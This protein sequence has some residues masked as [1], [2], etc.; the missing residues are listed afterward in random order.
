MTL[1]LTVT[2]PLQPGRYVLEIDMVH[3]GVAWFSQLGSRKLTVPVTV[4]RPWRPRRRWGRPG[5]VAEDVPVMEMH[6]L[7]ASE[8]ADIV[9]AANGRIA[10]V[11][12]QEVPGFDNRT[13]Y[14]TKST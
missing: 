14:V 9:T 7:A 5:D 8:V 10:W 11:D 13:Y 4:K 2:A 6:V 1:D 12:E 3:E